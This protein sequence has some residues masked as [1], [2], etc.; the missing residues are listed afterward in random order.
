MRPDARSVSLPAGEIRL[1]ARVWEHPAPA[2]P[3]VLVLH[4]IFESWRSLAGFAAELATDRTVLCLDLRG[5]G[6]SDRPAAGYRFADYAADVVA[7]LDD[8]GEPEVDLLG[9]SLGANVALFAAAAR[10]AALGRIVVI[11]PPVL[12]AEDWP[13]VRDMMRREWRLAREPLDVIVAEM[14]GTSARPR[15]WLEMIATALAR[16]ADGVFAAMAGG[17]QGTVPWPEILGRIAVPTLA[18]AADPTKPGAQ[19]TGHRLAEL[20]R[21]VPH[22][23][24]H[25]VPGAAHHVEVDQPAVLRQLVRS[26]LADRR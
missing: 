26:F 11:D 16:T 22:A 15:V 23:E 9:H 24:V 21:G 3:P 25:V 17:D 4:G 5:H 1:H 6:D 19:L 20:R 7:L 10:P 2:L 18:V 12:L 13:A 14:A 8:L